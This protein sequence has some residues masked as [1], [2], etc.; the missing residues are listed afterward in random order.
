MRQIGKH[1]IVAITGPCEE[2]AP[3]QASARPVAKAGPGALRQA[4]AWCGMTA[5]IA[6]TVLAATGCTSA[7]QSAHGSA[8]AVRLPACASRESAYRSIVIGIKASSAGQ[9]PMPGSP[10]AAVICRYGGTSG[11]S[12]SSSLK[13]TGQGRLAQL[14]SAMNGSRENPPGAFVNCLQSDGKSAVILVVYPG[15]SVRV[16]GI[17]PWC[18]RIATRSATYIPRG[19]VIKLIASWTGKW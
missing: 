7:A 2:G 12:L 9:T 5:A 19:G 15:T 17:D 3:G 10:V 8:A 1:K 11:L 4:A 6:A 14:Q 18:Q 16:I 13:V